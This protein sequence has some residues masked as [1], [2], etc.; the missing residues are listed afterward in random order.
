M[1]DLKIEI[2]SVFSE[3]FKISVDEIPDDLSYGEVAQWDSIGHLNLIVALEEEFNI[4]FS[5]DDVLDMLNIDLIHNIIDS[6]NA[7]STG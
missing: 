5:D 4:R 7:K 6:K 1:K 2:K 3:V